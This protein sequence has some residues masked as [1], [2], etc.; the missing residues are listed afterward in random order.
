VGTNSEPVI[1]NSGTAEPKVTIEIPAD[2][3]R[4]V[5]EKV[6]L[7]TRWRETTREAFTDAMDAGYVVEDFCFAERNGQKVGVYLLELRD[8]VTDPK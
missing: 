6:Q 1:T 8:K 4:I 7:A 3:N 5:K 2:L